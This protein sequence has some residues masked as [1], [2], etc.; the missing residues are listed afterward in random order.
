MKVE[1]V[2]VTETSSPVNTVMIHPQSP[3]RVSH[4]QSS[5][6]LVTQTITSSLSFSSPQQQP[7]QQQSSLETQPPAYSLHPSQPL[8]NPT[9]LSHN[10]AT[11]QQHVVAVEPLPLSDDVYIKSGESLIRSQLEKCIERKRKVPYM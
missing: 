11:L 4:A 7:Q 1:S 3:E 10:T 6:E 8:S 5:I 2:N 9:M